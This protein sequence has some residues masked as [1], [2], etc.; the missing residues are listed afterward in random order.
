MEMV[1]A[2]KLRYSQRVLLEARPYAR[3]L[4]KLLGRLAPTAQAAGHPFFAAR[5]VKRATLVLF[6]ADRGLCGS[7]NTVMIRQAEQ[8]LLEQRVGALELVCVG[9]RG[10]DYFGRRHWPIAA[11]FTDMGGKLDVGRSNE[12]AEFLCKRFLDG[13][14]DEIHL[15][16]NAFVST[17]IYRPNYVKFL[18]LDQSDLM[19]NMPQDE[20]EHGNLDYLLEPSQ[21]RVFDQLIPA[22]LKSKILITLAEGFASEHS[23]RMLAM[24][25]ATKNCDELVDS[26]TLALNKARQSSIT[27]DLLDIVGGAEALKG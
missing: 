15:L 5:N 6:T 7:Y 26:L 18:D 11:R 25:N 12:V 16:Y 23:A 19:A 9:R 20:H 27:R 2:A 13:E 14:T 1:S 22:Y 8:M 10:A 4:Q 21:E 24:T 17:A 3:N